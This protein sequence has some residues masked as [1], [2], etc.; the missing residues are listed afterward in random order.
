MKDYSKLQQKNCLVNI[1]INHK[2]KELNP[3]IL[4]V[5]FQKKT[6]LSKDEL[7]EIEFFF[8]LKRIEIC[9]I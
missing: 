6:P 9:I 8:Y 1:N 3:L 7:A 5:L 2:K 4:M